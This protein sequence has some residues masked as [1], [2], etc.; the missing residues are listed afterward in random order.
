MDLLAAQRKALYA[1]AYVLPDSVEA[2][3]LIIKASDTY[4]QFIQ[5]LPTGTPSVNRQRRMRGS[6]KNIVPT[7]PDDEPKT[8]SK[9]GNPSTQAQD[10]SSFFA[11]SSQRQLR[12]RS[13]NAFENESLPSIQKKQKSH[14]S[15]LISWVRI[16]KFK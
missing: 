7:L 6:T 2:F 16:V 3:K 5:T 14:A 9:S 13:N 1:A 11:R 15:G 12:E 4:Q 8:P 10:V